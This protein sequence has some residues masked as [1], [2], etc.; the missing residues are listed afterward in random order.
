MPSLPLVGYSW[1]LPVLVQ[2]L[3]TWRSPQQTRLGPFT[4]ELLL[5]TPVQ[6]A[7]PLQHDL[8]GVH[9]YIQGHRSSRNWAAIA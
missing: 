3:C 7:P 1:P 2:A 5:G 6:D 9:A 4:G 8:L